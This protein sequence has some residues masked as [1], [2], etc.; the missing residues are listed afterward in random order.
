MGLL[1]PVLSKRKN[2]ESF[3]YRPDIR[4]AYNFRAEGHDIEDCWTFKRAIENLIEQK[5]VVL[6]D[7]EIPSMTNNSLM[8]HS[9]GLVIVMISEDKGFDLALKAIIAIADVEKKPRVVANH[10]NG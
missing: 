4:C 2:P 6:K 7:E 9:N 8:A 1:Q 3:S 5:R 10:E